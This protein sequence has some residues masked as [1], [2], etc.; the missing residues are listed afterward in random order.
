MV[1][2]VFVLDCYLRL[3]AQSG[4]QLLLR[5]GENLTDMAALAGLLLAQPPGLPAAPVPAPCI[6]GNCPHGIEIHSKTC[7]NQPK[8]QI[9][10]R[11]LRTS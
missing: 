6:I 4:R 3:A 11:T 10:N 5:H 2:R 8:D 9:N 7:R 1:Q